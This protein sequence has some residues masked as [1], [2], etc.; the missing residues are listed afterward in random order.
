MP[1]SLTFKIDDQAVKKRLA[2]I[3]TGVADLSEPFTNMGEELGDFYGNEVFES[4]GKALGENWKPLSPAT[5]K[6]RRER[7]L[8]YA[9]APIA[10]DKILIWTGAL[11]KGL[12]KTAERMR[13]T[14]E[15]TVEYF[16]YNQP[17]RRML[18]INS[19]VMEIALK[20]IRQHLHNLIYR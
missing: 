6:L 2:K 20:H 10:T 8:H 3:A 12:K 15:N 16:K 7:R 17:K 13:L 4:Q 18:A 11:K 19:K 1:L 5:L 9:K 14:I